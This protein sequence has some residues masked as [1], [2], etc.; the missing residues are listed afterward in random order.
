MNDTNSP[1]HQEVQDTV[2]QPPAPPPGAGAIPG[3]ERGVLD[4]LGAIKAGR[5]NPKEMKTDD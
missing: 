4:L 5:L 2:P 1:K 3:S